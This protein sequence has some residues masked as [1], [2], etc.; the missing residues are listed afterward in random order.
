MHSGANHSACDVIRCR[1]ADYSL[2]GPTSAV[3]V[4]EK[5]FICEVTLDIPKSD[6]LGSSAAVRRMF[7]AAKSLQ[8]C[9]VT[10]QDVNKSFTCE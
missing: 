6:T 7:R 5:A 1:E 4:P 9:L 2:K 10:C 8:C 3:V